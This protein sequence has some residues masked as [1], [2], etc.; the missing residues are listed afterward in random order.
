MKCQE[1]IRDH[2]VISRGLDILDGMVQKMENGLRI[3]IADVTVILKFLSVFVDEYHSEDRTAMTGI[4]DALRAKAGR[5]FVQ[6]SRHL[7]S[8]LRKHFIRENAAVSE[9]L[10]FLPD[11]AYLERKYA[12]KKHIGRR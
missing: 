10:G 8:L 9:Q 7:C 4:E 2:V 11:F 6:S 5:D 12:P 3:E 1:V